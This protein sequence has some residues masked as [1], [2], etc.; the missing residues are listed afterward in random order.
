M[1]P[2]ADLEDVDS[3]TRKAGAED[4][5]RFHRVAVCYPRTGQEVLDNQP[6]EGRTGL[7]EVVDR[8]P[9]E[10]AREADS[11]WLTEE[12]RIEGLMDR[13]EH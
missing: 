8:I 3:H 12:K 7:Q 5:A 9:C 1:Q 2:S 10:E 4:S 6:I 13:R 11:R